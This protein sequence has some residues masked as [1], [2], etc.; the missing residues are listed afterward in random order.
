MS[1]ECFTISS[2]LSLSQRYPLSPIQDGA[3]P[4]R[5]VEPRV[6]ACVLSARF[7]PMEQR[8][9]TLALAALNEQEQSTHNTFAASSLS[10]PPQSPKSASL[11]APMMQSPLT[12]PK[13][14]AR[15]LILQLKLTDE[16][17]S[18]VAKNFLEEQRK[19][20]RLNIPGVRFNGFDEFPYKG[21]LTT[22]ALVVENTLIGEGTHNRIFSSL[23][24]PT[25]KHTLPSQIEEQ[26][27]SKAQRVAMRVGRDPNAPFS[28]VR[29]LLA[30]ALAINNNVVPDGIDLAQLVLRVPGGAT[31]SIH[32]LLTG[33]LTKVDFLTSAS[34]TKSILKTLEAIAGGIAFFHNAGLVHRDIKGPNTLYGTHEEPHLWTGKLIDYDFVTAEFTTP[35]RTTGTPAYLDPLM[36]GTAEESLLNQRNRIGIQTKAGDIYAFGLTIHNSVL[37]P[38]MKKWAEKIGEGH[39]TSCKKM[40]TLIE[41]LSPKV[42]PGPF[43]NE[44]LTS[45]SKNHGYAV[46]VERHGVVEES[47]H[48][49]PTIDEGLNECFG[50]LFDYVWPFFNNNRSEYRALRDL[51]TISLEMRH[52][53]LSQRHSIGAVQQLLK[54][55]YEKALQ[56]DQGVC[57]Q[58]SGLT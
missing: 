42:I 20:V 25:K 3:R 48:H 7:G 22:Q 8:S 5:A 46:Y 56:S 36:F 49:H 58:S 41:M 24:F 39:P 44:C 34:P 35:V 1:S 51:A 10:T 16:R 54:D 4:A 33:D 32:P 11:G 6:R 52:P 26:S 40:N 43:T 53:D 50:R 12:T 47:I 57:A 18:A 28:A 2:Q 19:L 55:L 38:I 13:K 14:V 29:G 15:S 21:L 45:F 27:P 37:I 31:H 30:K 17:A 23:Y 9:Q